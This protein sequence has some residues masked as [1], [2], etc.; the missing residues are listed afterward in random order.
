MDIAT[1]VILVVSGLLVGFIN[2][3]AGGGTIISMT[4]FMSLGLPPMIANGTNRIPIVLQNLVAVVNYSKSKILNIKTSLKYALPVAL[5]SILGS[6]IALNISDIVFN[7]LFI[8][9]IVFMIIMIVFKPKL[10]LNENPIKKNSPFSISQWIIL[11][12]IGIYGGFIHVGIGYF[13]IALIV[14]ARGYD[15]L[16]ANAIKNLVVLIYAPIS[17]IPFILYGNIRYDYGLVHA[18]GNIIGA[19][20]ASRLATL[21]GSKVIRYILIAFMLL[22][23]LQVVRMLS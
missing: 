14:L 6:N 18:I 1:V 22:S 3:L 10:W 16:H 19:Y 2:T 17:L 23:C 7:Y 9:V 4:I 12:V 5:G 21:F 13:I 20:V 11:F 15:L 8:M